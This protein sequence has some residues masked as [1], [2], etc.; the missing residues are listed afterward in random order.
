MAVKS[1][2]EMTEAALAT[3]N[4]ST[5]TLLVPKGLYHLLLRPEASVPTT[6]SI[7]A[8]GPWRGLVAS[9]PPGFVIA[10]TGTIAPLP[11]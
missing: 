8:W 9:E 10:V 1:S 4:C 5:A 11:S 7:R 6:P 2:Y 3:L